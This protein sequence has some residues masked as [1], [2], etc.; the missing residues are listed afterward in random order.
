MYNV[1]QYNLSVRAQERQKYEEQQFA[2]YL[3]RHEGTPYSIQTTRS[4][5]QNAS[6]PKAKPSSRK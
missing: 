6:T 3:L 4:W 5:P 1:H 2:K